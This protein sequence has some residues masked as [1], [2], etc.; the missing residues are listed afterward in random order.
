MAV[1]ARDALGN[2]GRS[3]IIRFTID[4]TPPIINVLSPLNDS[5]QKNPI[6][7]EATISEMTSWITYSFDGN[8]NITMTNNNTS[9]NT[10]EG[11]HYLVLY[12]ADTAGNV[13]ASKHV[14]FIVDM[15]PP[16]ITHISQYLPVQDIKPETEV[17]VNATVIDASSGVRSVTL[18]YTIGDGRWIVLNMTNL[19]ENIWGTNIIPFNSGTRVTYLISAEDRA[20]NI[21]A[22]PLVTY[23]YPNQLSE[24]SILAIGTIS[25]LAVCSILV[26]MLV[27][28]KRKKSIPST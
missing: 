26:I 20:G 6:R 8:R 4:T 19:H 3:G 17:N 23:E 5:Y 10:S 25:I 28:S 22:S 11:T 12:A 13:A 14:D 21:I 16:N 2:T 9:I 18:N 7:L 1:Y 27:L 24:F 15:S